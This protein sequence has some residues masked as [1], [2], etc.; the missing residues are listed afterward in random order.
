M[1]ETNTTIYLPI[2]DKTVTAEAGC[3]Y[4]MPD[5]QPEVRR[6]LRVKTTLLPT[7]AYVGGGKAEFAGTVRYD[8]L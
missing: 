4:A 2:C 6:L 7:T 1:H 8:V 5:Y 3:D